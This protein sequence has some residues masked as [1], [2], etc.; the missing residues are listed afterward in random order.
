MAATT[1][2]NFDNLWTHFETAINNGSVD[3]IELAAA[4]KNAIGV[5]GIH[6]LA[7]RYE[8]VCKFYL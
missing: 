6:F 2:L 1:N 7:V 5:A 4:M 3:N 8:F